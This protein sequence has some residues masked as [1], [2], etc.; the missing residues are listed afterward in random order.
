MENLNFAL[1]VTVMGMGITFLVLI[2]L[3]I[4]LMGMNNLW[5]RFTNKPAP[6]AEA[7]RAV[8]A[9]GAVDTNAEPAAGD[10]ENQAASET[11]GL[12]GS[13]IAVISAAIAAS[14]ETSTQNIRI[15]SVRRVER[16]GQG[17]AWSQAGRQEIINARQRF[18]ERRGN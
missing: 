6:A 16:A 9:A 1:V 7:K 14:L 15:A 2:I 10:T 12:P 4:L 13:L 5:D 8:L 17:Y 11:V 3:S 18:F